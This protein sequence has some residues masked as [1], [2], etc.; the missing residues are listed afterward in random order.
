MYICFISNV[1]RREDPKGT[2]Q[3]SLKYSDE[4]MDT[5]PV[6]RVPPPR[7][8]L[9]R[10]PLETMTRENNL[11]RRGGAEERAPLIPSQRQTRPGDVSSSAALPE[12]PRPNERE[13]PIQTRKRSGPAESDGFDYYVGYA[14]EH[15]Q[16]L[17]YV[18]IL[19]L[20]PLP[21]PC[22]AITACFNS[23]FAV[24]CVLCAYILLD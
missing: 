14:P 2:S 5:Q 22:V 7:R 24:F 1:E 13:Y 17:P 23:T 6:T 10:P 9:G 4:P 12:Y 11:P 15:A 18:D 20:L 16:P 21:Y 3:S 8:D 19:S